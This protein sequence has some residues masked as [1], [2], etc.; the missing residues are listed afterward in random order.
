MTDLE[1][2]TD[3]RPLEN[4]NFC[5]GDLSIDDSREEASNKNTPMVGLPNPVLLTRG[6]LL[7]FATGGPDDSQRQENV[8]RSTFDHKELIV[9]A[10]DNDTA[11][12]DYEKGQNVPHSYSEAVQIGPQ[13]KSRLDNK[14]P[15]TDSDRRESQGWIIPPKLQGGGLKPEDVVSSSVMVDES[16]RSLGWFY[17]T[18]NLS[19]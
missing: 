1:A 7:T 2:Q 4:N 3:Q 15:P 6:A 14:A 19:N 9:T 18:Q 12:I 5:S 10:L 8:R 16:K 13:R 11:V 17:P